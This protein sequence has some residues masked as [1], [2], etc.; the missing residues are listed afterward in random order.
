MK[1]IL[2]YDFSDFSNIDYEKSLKNGYGGE[3]MLKF[4]LAQKFACELNKFGTS[5]NKA[6]LLQNCPV[7]L[8]L[9]PS[10]CGSGYEHPDN[11]P[12]TKNFLLTLYRVLNIIPYAY[13]NENLGRVF[14]SVTPLERERER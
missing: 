3:F 9:P 6:I 13:K 1:N 5:Q 12:L 14:R 7:D 10:P 11:I 2:C 8:E 4:I